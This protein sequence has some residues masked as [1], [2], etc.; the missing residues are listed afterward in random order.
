MQEYKKNTN[1]MPE[2]APFQHL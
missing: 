1:K 2:N